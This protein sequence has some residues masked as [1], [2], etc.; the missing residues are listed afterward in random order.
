MGFIIILLLS[1]LEM[2]NFFITNGEYDN[3]IIIIPIIMLSILIYGFQNILDLG[4]YLE[5]KFTLLYVN[6]YISNNH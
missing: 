2:R 1:Y 4:I 6:F 5:K 3:A